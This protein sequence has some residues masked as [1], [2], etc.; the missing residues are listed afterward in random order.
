MANLFAKASQWLSDVRVAT[1]SEDVEIKVGDT[2]IPTKA[3]V[4]STNA[5]TN[6][7]GVK[8]QT[9][10]HHFIIKTLFLISNSVV[11]DRGLLIRRAGKLYE[12]G[13]DKRALWEYND[14]A[15]VDTII[16]TVL[17]G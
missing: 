4:S 13:Y 5:D 17:K 14:P 15:G 3:T 1:C 10:Y 16:M 8:L 2:W 6:Q 7:S 11:L 12:I 9:Q